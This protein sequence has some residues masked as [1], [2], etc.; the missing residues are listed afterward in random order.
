LDGANS[1]AEPNKYRTEFSLEG[2]PNVNEFVDR[3]VEMAEL[4]RVFISKSNERR[5]TVFVLRGLGGIGKTQLA[6]EFARRFRSEFSSVFWLD[7]SSKSSV[8]KCIAD[9][10]SRIPEGQIA[11]NS[12]SMVADSSAGIDAIVKD[13]LVWLAQP[14]NTRWLIIFDNVDRDY[15]PGCD[16]TDAYDVTSYFS[17]ADHGSVLIT[18]RLARLEQLGASRQVRKVLRDQAEAILKTWYKGKI[19]MLK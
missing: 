10:A 11:Y 9:C 1:S 15:E 3:P 12:R 13:V 8:K 14:Q 5:Q 6:V 17:G 4:E 18:T 7:G 16:D 2:V 19:G